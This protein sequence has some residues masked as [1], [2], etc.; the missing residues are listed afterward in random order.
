MYVSGPLSSIFN[1]VNC[2]VM[3][4]LLHAGQARSRLTPPA[5]VHGPTCRVGQPPAAGPAGHRGLAR[6][7]AGDSRARPPEQQRAYQIAPAMSELGPERNAGQLRHVV[8][9]SKPKRRA[10]SPSVGELITC[11]GT[12]LGKV[13]VRRD[14]RW[15]P[16]DAGT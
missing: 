4:S 10:S 16:A 3:L 12:G 1:F 9:E 15:L 13:T 8:Q 11:H 7:S 5:A 6:S 14:P 2:W